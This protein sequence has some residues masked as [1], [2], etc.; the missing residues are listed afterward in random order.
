[1]LNPFT[2]EWIQQGAGKTYCHC[3]TMKAAMEAASR[4]TTEDVA[5][6]MAQQVLDL[7]NSSPV[8]PTASQIAHAIGFVRIRDNRLSKDNQ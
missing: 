7:V 3:G 1:M 5:M 8:T 6:R 4:A 2:V